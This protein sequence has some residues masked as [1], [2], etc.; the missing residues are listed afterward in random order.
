MSDAGFVAYAALVAWIL[1]SLVAFFVMRT[2]KAALFT[3]FGG[4]LFLPEGAFFKLP[5]FPPIGKTSIP[6]LCVILGCAMRLQGR[7]LR[8]P[9]DRWVTLFTLAILAGGIGIALTNRDSQTYGWT[10][11][12]VPALSI[13]D[14]MAVS[15]GSVLQ[16]ALPFFVGTAVI[17]TSQHLRTMFRFI[18]AAGVI[19]AF[20]ALLEIRVSPQLHRWIYGYAQHADFMQTMRFGGYRPMVFMPHGLAV[21]LFFVVTA[22][23]AFGLGRTRTSIWGISPGYVGVFLTMILV[24]CKSTGAIVYGLVACP[25]VALRMTG[26]K[27]KI[28]VVVGVFVL[29][30][31]LLRESN[32]FPV[33]SVLSVASIFGPERSESLSFRFENEDKL[34]FKASERPW[35][36]WGQS[37][38][39]LVYDEVGNVAS[40]TDGAWIIVLGTQ[41]VLGFVCV[42]G[43]IVIPIFLAVRR[44]RR[45]MDKQDRSLVTTLAL[46]VAIT[47][48]DLIPN[49]LFSNYPFFLSGALL[50][51]SETLK[52]PAVP[53]FVSGP[54]GYGVPA[55]PAWPMGSDGRSDLARLS[56]T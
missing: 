46:M 25:V 28:A 16:V 9:K 33:K 6:Y 14:G 50:T 4:A 5:Y 27:R 35:F 2:E 10:K 3:I 32:V 26:L 21:A 45:I 34:L 52:G 20:P 1:I 37:G 22:L 54:P 8:P 13:K 19:Y 49:G 31:P 18:G 42:F 38:R 30:Y 39:N 36:G 53:R 7:V 17:R 44:S 56:P 23:A 29:L 55:D 47:A 43:M 41:G 12:T 40:V 48:F 15:M 51:L 11:F 24:L